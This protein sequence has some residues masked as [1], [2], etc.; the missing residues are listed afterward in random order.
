[1]N[2]FQ[3][4]ATSNREA[5]L[6]ISQVFA[7]FYPQASDLL[8]LADTYAPSLK[9]VYYY[10]NATLR[11]HARL[12][13]AS[14][15]L[16]TEQERE[17]ASCTEGLIDALTCAPHDCLKPLFKDVLGLIETFVH[18]MGPNLFHTCAGST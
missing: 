16:L 8:D 4:L 7:S 11:Y 15:T 9:F 5:L 13:F 2:V 6:D 17:F 3:P 12:I 1:M 14:Q 10:T 18:L